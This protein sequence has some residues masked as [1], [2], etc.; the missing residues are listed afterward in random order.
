MIEPSVGRVVWYF[1][2][3]DDPRLQRDDNAPLA[4]I[5]SMVKPGGLI[6]LMVAAQD[7][8][9]VGRTNVVL[10]QDDPPSDANVAAGYA[11]WMPYQKGQAAKTE[12]LER[13]LK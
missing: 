13:K 5:I 12:E 6:N 7:G 11:A 9:P 10:V 4:A 8:H 2:A 3:A 1:P